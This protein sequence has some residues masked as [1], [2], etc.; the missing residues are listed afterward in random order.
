MRAQRAED[1]V[2]RVLGAG[3]K[4]RASLG[5]ALAAVPLGLYP[6]LKG[7]IGEGPNHSNFSDQSSVNILANS[8]IFARK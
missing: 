6:E 3:I 4:S 1:L 8:G 7:S 2:E 5:G